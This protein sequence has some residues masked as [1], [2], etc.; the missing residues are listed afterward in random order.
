MF[1]SLDKVRKPVGR[2]GQARRY[3]MK[4]TR[5][6]FIFGQGEED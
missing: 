1:S 4:R 3:D 2:P 5:N 6:V